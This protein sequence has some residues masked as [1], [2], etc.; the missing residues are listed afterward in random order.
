M[1]YARTG[2]IDFLKLLGCRSIW[3]GSGAANGW[4]T[5]VI[6][7]GSRRIGIMGLGVL[8]QA[9][10][11]ALGRFGFSLAGWSRSVHTVP[12]VACHAGAAGLPAFLAGCDILVCLLPLTPQ[13]RGILNAGLFNELPRGAAVVNVGRGPHLVADDLLAALEQGQISAAVVDVTDPEPPPPQHPFWSHPRIWLTPHIA[14]TVQ[15]ESGADAVIANIRR[16]LRG[17]APIGLVDRARGY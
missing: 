1:D 5:W 13:T 9:V 10:L 12:G 11:E 4:R 7:A 8:G 17:E 14:S 3:N 6:P 15:P 16:H 2:M